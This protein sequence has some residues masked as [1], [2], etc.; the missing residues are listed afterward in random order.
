M[1]ISIHLYILYIYTLFFPKIK[2]NG[3]MR[4]TTTHN[5]NNFYFVLLLSI[6]IVLLSPF[7]RTSSPSRETLTFSMV[8]D[9]DRDSKDVENPFLWRSVKKT[10][11]LIPLENSSNYTIHFDVNS[12]VLLTSRTATKSRSMELSAAIKYRNKSFVFCDATG[13]VLRL[14]DNKVYPRQQILSGS[15]KTSKPFKTEWATV[16]DDMIWLG[17]NGKEWVDEQG[18]V[19]HRMLEWIK[20]IDRTG[21]IRNIDWA[22]NYRALRTVTNTTFPGYLWN[23]A[24]EWDESIRRFVILPRKES[25][26]IPYDPIRDETLGSNLLLLADETFENIT[27]RRLEPFE[28]DWGFSAVRQIPN[29]PEKY[30]ALKVKE[31]NGTTSTKLTVFDLHGR[32]YLYP[33]PYLEITDLDKNV[34][35]EGLLFD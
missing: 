3:K 24:V 30:L 11:L 13:S 10:G 6:A 32:Y 26:D 27:V 1:L 2:Y 19:V 12:S 28:S 18:R 25:S 5:N 14:R 15:G 9:L 23:E 7:S 33:E 8:S 35:F 20:T 21:R 4:R 16:K 29:D 34:K 22:S 31:V 17:S